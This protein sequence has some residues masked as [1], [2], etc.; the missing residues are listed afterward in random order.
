MRAEELVREARGA[1]EAKKQK[2]AHT[3]KSP[4]NVQRSAARWRPK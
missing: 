4:S 2:K 3:K 1:Q